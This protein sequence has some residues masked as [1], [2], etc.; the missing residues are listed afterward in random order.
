[1]TQQSG[2]PG[3]ERFRA[4]GEGALMDG[5]QFG[6]RSA[7]R[8]CNEPSEG[9]PGRPVHRVSHLFD[10]LAVTDRVQVAIAAYRAGRVD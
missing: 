10:K 5:F 1:M 6:Q 4:F 7:R 9:E 2:P 3:A 8:P